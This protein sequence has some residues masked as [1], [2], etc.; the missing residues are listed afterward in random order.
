MDGG[1]YGSQEEN[2]A[3]MNALEILDELEA[4]MRAGG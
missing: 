2:D 1:A 4:M 3:F